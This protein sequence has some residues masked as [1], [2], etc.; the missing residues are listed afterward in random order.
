MPHFVFI[1]QKLPFLPLVSIPCSTYK[2]WR[3]SSFE[4]RNVGPD[5]KIA[6]AISTGPN[7]RSFS[8]YGFL[9]GGA[10][11]AS[12]ALKIQDVG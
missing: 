6:D 10:S 11:N 1:E 4:V 2:T 7:P 12:G 3:P 5:L 9:F 8:Q